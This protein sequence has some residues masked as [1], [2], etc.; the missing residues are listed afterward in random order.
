MISTG[1]DA[2]YLAVTFPPI[3]SHIAWS[4]LLG[5]LDIHANRVHGILAICS[6]LALRG[7]SYGFLCVESMFEAG[8]SLH[9][10][11]T[12]SIIHAP[13]EL[14]LICPILGCGRSTGHGARR[15]LPAGALSAQLP[16][17]VHHLLQ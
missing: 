4:V 10:T 14:P 15:T 5:I 9:L 13:F 6:L 3:P 8:E 7:T 2:A 1:D 17:G 11:T 16:P 12:F